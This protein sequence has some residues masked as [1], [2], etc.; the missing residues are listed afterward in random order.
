MSYCHGKIEKSLLGHSFK[1]MCQEYPRI[2]LI[3][4]VIQN[5][6]MRKL[7]EETATG[8]ALVVKRD[9]I[10]KELPAKELLRTLPKEE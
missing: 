8:G 1:V 5:N 10:V 2:I 3:G 6:A 7:V 4:T 9:G